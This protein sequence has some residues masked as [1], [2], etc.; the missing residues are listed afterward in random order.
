MASLHLSTVAA[1][2]SVL[3]MTGLAGKCGSNHWQC[4]DGAC[5]L[6]SWRC[7]GAGDCLDGSDE[8]DCSCPPEYFE[9][10]DGTLCVMESAVCDGQT[11]CPDGSDEL[12]CNLYEGCLT[13]D[14][15]C[16]NS[17]CISLSLRCNEFDDCGDGSDEEGCGYCGDLN[18]RCP[19]GTCLTLRERCDGVPHCSDGRDEPVTCG[20]MCRD[21]NGG[22]SH[23]CTDQLWGAMCSCPSG[24]KLSANGAKCEDVDECAQPYGPCM[25][26][27]I[28]TKGSFQCR[29]RPGFQLQGGNVCQTQ[30]N[31]TK[32]LTTK[33]GLLGLIAVNDRSFLPLTGI[34]SNPLALTFDFEQNLVFWADGNGNIYKTLD[35][36]SS[37]LYSGQTG[38]K[39]LAVD[40]LNGQLYWTNAELKG[41]YTGAYDGSSVGVVLSK[42]TDP[43]DLVLLPTE[44]TMFW[45]NKGPNILTIESAAMDGFL[46]TS[47]MV[48]TAQLPRG[49]A[50]DVAARRLYWI[51][52]FKKSVETVKVDGTG[53][54][55]FREFF[56]GRVG[57]NLAVFNG[58]FYWTEDRRLWQAPENQPS[59]KNFLLKGE[60]TTV[61]VYHELQQ[62]RGLSPC[63]KSGCQLC[64]PSLTSLSGYT[65]SCSEGKLSVQRGSCEWFK[66]AYATPTTIYTLEYTTNGPVKSI[67]FSSD[68]DIQAFDVDWKR[69]LVICANLTGHVK[70]HVLREGRSEYIPTLKP[71]C[72]VRVDQKTGNFYWVSC[73]E[74]SV[75]ATHISLPDQSVS[76]HLYQ[77]SGEINDLFVDWQRGQLYWLEDSQII[78]MKL[79]LLGGN[80]KAIYRSEDK[81]IGHVVF[82]RRAYSVVWHSQNELQVLSLLKRKKYTA[83]EGWTFPG[84]IAAAYEPYIVTVLNDVITLWKRQDGTRVKAVTVESA[85]VD[86]TVALNELQQ[87]APLSSPGTDCEKPSMLCKETSLCMQQAWLCDGTKDCPDGSDEMNCRELCSK[88]GDFQCK[89]GR[90]CVARYLLCN[91]RPDCTDGSDEMSCSPTTNT[92]NV[93]PLRCRLGSKLCRDGSD[94]VHHSHVC[95]GQF[96]CKDGS[97]EDGCERW[98]KADQFQCAHGRMCIDKKLVCDGTPQCQDRSDEM[99]CFTRTKSCSHRC[100]NKTRCIPDTFLCDGEKDCLD[101]TDE[102][103]C[104]ELSSVAATPKI[105][106]TPEPV[107]E[108]PSE[109]CPGTSLCISQ[110]QLCDGMLD[111]PDG[112][113]ELHCLHACSDPGHFLCKNKRKCV[114]RA[115]VCDGD[116]HCKDGSD[117]EDCGQ[118]PPGIKK[119]PEPVCESPSEMCPGTS[120]CISQSQLCDGMLDCPDGFDELHCLHTC[121]D[122]G[123]FLCKNKRKCVEQALLC[124]GRSDCSDGSDE[125]QCPTCPLH[126]DE[127]T[128]CLTSQQFCDGRMDCKDGL[129]ERNC[130]KPGK[131]P[132]KSSLKCP[133]GFKPCR[134]GSDCILYNHVCDG[135]KDCKDGSDERN[136][137]KQCNKDQFQCAHGRMCIDKKLVCDG[138]PQCQDR[139]DEMDCFTRTKS[140]S[141]RCD[142]KTRCISDTFLCDGEKDCLDGTDEA[143]CRELSSVAAT[144]KIEKTPE[145]VCENP[146]EMCPGT[147]LCISQSQLCDGMLDCPD[148]FDELHCLHACSDPGHFL[149]K[150]K[151][152]CVERALVCDGRSDCSDGSDE[153]QC[154]TCPLHCDEGTVCLT[155]QQFCDG[156][157]DC[158]D[159]LDERNCYKPGKK[160]TKSSLKCPLGFKPCRDGS[161]CILYN[162]VCD[163]EK[164]CKDGSDERN[165]EKQ[166][167]KDQFQCAH[168]RMCIDKKLVCD[169]TPQCQDRSDEMDCF[170]R[171]ESCSHRCDNKT[172]CIS[173]TFLCDG[174]KDCLDGTDEADCPGDSTDTKASS[175]VVPI[176]LSAN[177]DCRS[178]SMFCESTSL[179]MSPTQLCDGKLD[180]P[181]GSDELSCIDSCQ[182]KGD[183]LC[184]EQKKCI[185]VHLR[186]DGRS[187]CTDGSDEADCLAPGFKCRLGS[188]LC[189]DGSDCILNTHVCDGELDCKDGSDEDGCDLQCNQGQF[190]CRNSRMCISRKQV[191][192]GVPQ[193][194]DN[195][196]ESTC[197]KPSRSCALRCDQNSHC[198]PEIFICNGIR[199]CWDGSD[200]TDCGNPGPH[201]LCKSPFIPCLATSKCISQ[202]QLCDGKKDCTD[203]SDERPCLQSCPYDGDD[204]LCKDRRRCI[205]RNLVCDG[206]P[207]CTDA[208]DEVDCP[209]VAAYSTEDTPMKCRLG[210]TPCKD[211]SDCILHS[212]LCD[213]ENDCKDGSDEEGCDV[214]CKTGQFQCAHGRK[215]IDA[216]FVC[217]GKPQC[218]DR[219]DEMDCFQRTKSCSHR[220]DNKT[221]CIPK[222][223]LCDGERDCI[224]GTDESDCGYPTQ[225]QRCEAPSVLCRGGKLCI[226]NSKLCDGKRDCPDGF[227]EEAC[228]KKCPKSGD[229][230]CKDRRKCVENGLVCD[231]RPDCNDSSDEEGCPRVPVKPNKPG[232]LKCRLGWR[233]CKDGSKCV[234]YSHVCDGE[235]DCKDGSDEDDCQYQ[236]RPDQFQCAHGRLCIDKKLVC[237]GTPQC[238]DRSD[239]MDCFTRTKSCSHRCDNKTRCI[240]D[241]FLCDGEKDCLDGTD[242][243]DCTE[244]NTKKSGPP[245]LK[246][247]VGFRPC[248]DG[249]ECILSSHMCDGE[250]DCKDRS[251]EQ[252]CRRKVVPEA[253]PDK[254][255]PEPVCE[256]PSVMCP[257]TSLCISQSQLCDG[258]LDCPDGFDELHCLHACS[259]PGHFLCKNKRKCVE[260]ALVCDGRSDC[261]DGSDEAQCPTC[262]LHC[263]E[264]TVCLTS[265]QFCDGRMDCKD[266]FDEKKCHKGQKNTAGSSAL[267]CRL[268]FKPCRDGSECI[269]SS[270]VC[271]G[272][273]DCKD[274]SD[275]KDCER[276]CKKSQFQCAHGKMCIDQKQVC[277]GTPQCQDRSDEV[278]CFKPSESCS[279]HCDNRTRCI[280]ESFL[281]D[282]ERDCLDGTDETSCAKE[283]CL[284]GQFQ[285]VNGQCVPVSVR[286]DG[287]ADCYDQSD[288]KSC[289][290]PPH[291]PLEQRCPNSHVCL[292]K[293]WFCDGHKDCPDGSDEQNCKASPVQCGAFQ[294]SCASKDQ[295]IP[296]F[297]RCDGVN[298]CKDHS[299]E[300]GCG[301]TKCSTHM[302]KCGSEE[303]LDYRL[304]CDGTANCLDES[305]EGP[306]CRSNNCSGPNPPRCE[307]ICINTPHG[308]K[309][310]C[311]PGFRIQPDG[312]YCADV[313]ECMESRPPVCTHKC[314]N[315]HGS[316][317]CKCHP[318]FILE[319]D[320][321]SCKTQKE[322]S[323]L[324][325]VQYEVLFMGLRSSNMEMLLSPG[326]KPI[327]SLDYDWKEQRVFWVCLQEQSIKYAVHGEK[328]YIK[329]LVKGV[330]SDSIA[331]DWLARNL[332]WVD[333]VA[334]Q[335]LAVRIGDSVLKQQNVT[336]ILDEDLEQPRSLVLLPQKGIMLWSAIGK[337]PRIE[338]AGMDGSER[339]LLLGHGLNWPVALAVDIVTDRIYWADEKLQC[340]GSATMD[341]KDIRLLQL[342]ETS[343]LYSVAVFNDMVYWSDTRRQA[344]HGAHKL[345][346]KNRK[347]ILKRPGQPFGLK[348]V[349]PLIQYKVP[350]PCERLRCSH[351]C[352]LSPEGSASCRCPTGL[353]LAEDGFTCSP[354]VNSSSFLLLLSPTRLTKVFTR[355]L[356]GQVGLKQWPTHQAQSLPGINEALDMDLVLSD[357][358]L[359][360]A[361]VGQ[362][363]VAKI[364]LGD[365]MMPEL[366]MLQ[367]SGDIITALAVDWITHNLY[368][369][370]S[371]KPQIYATSAGGTFT[372][373]V[374]QAR[375]QDPTSIALHPPTG[376]MCFTAMETS[377]KDVLPQVDCAAMDGR[378]QMVLWRK[379]R[380]PNFLTFSS[381][382]TTVYW[383]DVATELICSVGI[384][385][386]NYREYKTG[387][388]SPLI[389][390]LTRSE[391][392]LFWITR[393]NGTTSVWFSDGI[394]PKKLWFEVE[395]NLIALK[396]FSTNSQKGTNLCAKN[397]GGCSHLCLAYPGG[398]TCRCTHDYIAVHENQCVSGD[399][400]PTGSKPCRDGYKCL[401]T[402]RFC[403]QIPDC[404]DG[405]DEEGCHMQE[406]EVLVH[407]MGGQSCNSDLCNGR[408]SCEMQKGKPVCNC[409][410]GYAGQFCQDEAS[411]SVPIILTVIFII[412]LVIL[413]AAVMRWRRWKSR[414]GLSLDKETLM[415]DMEEQEACS[416][417]FSNELYNPVEE[418][419][420][421]CVE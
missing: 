328:G 401:S 283:P 217:D 143:D 22:C 136:C 119:S 333:G 117:E 121:S 3:L 351:M 192:D 215:C 332:Y 11:Q 296:T 299:D 350:N 412:S 366:Q 191:C 103:D 320:G 277:D 41:I 176:T 341:G 38:I 324:A 407:A 194:P 297:W 45:I 246:C 259:D 371:K 91:G 174:E 392:I 25:H 303:C 368:W 361:D 152:K 184:K 212:H 377:G 418:E 172:R 13:G 70:V 222:N 235:V 17:I 68:E 20:K 267:K 57:Q 165:C 155:S 51:S 339:K 148:G 118:K 340:I 67:L 376:R 175:K 399:Q 140:C 311:Q 316:Y 334:G 98:C 47:L 403:D 396:A 273:K 53:R 287:H 262:P 276:Q 110:S 290:K 342:T 209:T 87:D 223:F 27:C 357:D 253:S 248:R 359:Y 237:D 420:S 249:S 314:M 266:G 383:A 100:D 293:E 134:D 9:C 15:K 220:C 421:T 168:G 352:V 234:L 239:E 105:E 289:R 337:K 292:L 345:T 365:S 308:A 398:R 409:A 135:E 221:R 327:F 93:A 394:Q 125:A 233:P 178:P 147:S 127:G 197:W 363:S 370:S 43:T 372:S 153:A 33:K 310:G 69:G 44:S 161:D 335:I 317:M 230:L 133:L 96:D 187:D 271:D 151:R 145:P 373:V 49:L 128:V 417:N 219:S 413:A 6:S 378:N 338:Q 144:P 63:R 302:F 329:T 300:A 90:N 400:C 390:S 112:F 29:C 251:D 10:F 169:G 179:C 315:T 362:A 282:G 257:G 71:V 166:C 114:E 55:T 306:G 12:N 395:T 281:C 374:L 107:C 95:D 405:S 244:S 156:R 321:S 123:H 73:D 157:M 232:P 242:E 231:G 225:L 8:M 14:W 124:D 154:P 196:D 284:R 213:G 48:V 275:E 238:Q 382:G 252:D 216:S 106:K 385:G 77:A 183:F 130:Y 150:N 260:R 240:P 115:L 109:M 50:L 265:Q 247:A 101:G 102:A 226:S 397:N 408:G 388:A 207:H 162:H 62:P 313:D 243:A 116:K 205:D 46:R 309:C 274:G 206:H 229:F 39:S 354:P 419:Q 80:A 74:L 298:D 142:N 173:D 177:Q 170:K 323:L 294:W 163:G 286:C 5:I 305:D 391:N 211:G 65:C 189:R 97:D 18:V 406:N 198:I 181:D 84:L 227:D 4:D 224:D 37:V 280:P 415:K 349:H 137:E 120:L 64:M 218:Q 228:F 195:S 56:K 199:D 245:S 364:K 347:V 126:C 146:S 7:D 369:S 331:V 132:T 32:L 99:D 384:D 85:I 188:K 54:H 360:V 261:S 402:T 34:S 301:Q 158:K 40:W 254:K 193:C 336:V 23:T 61:M 381:Q 66:L 411:S 164:D 94:C 21:K 325:S 204:F 270:H 367:L 358:T 258:M 1:V 241:T 210:L 35:Q 279:H 375:L 138:T 393:F 208:S 307:H 182:E 356:H 78:T 149:C 36:K 264:G 312:L 291:C 256:N 167:N 416:E 92:K 86:V 404:Q 111:C 59:K 202:S 250:K 344:I 272:E 88:R 82:D 278:N 122:P 76:S 343:S 89:D 79:G 319:P 72:V 75:G 31:D 42:D 353:L 19:N 326:L 180:C 28:N 255:T 160:P 269:L 380:L 108:N 386:S 200:E 16:K 318:E 30:G 201:S 288:E 171:T 81:S 285:C 346:G 83:G 24:M 387:T 139:S 322:P 52:E 190:Q 26:I 185:E 214:N 104:R 263:D 131:K 268:G 129:D 295:C 186:C 203:G 2:F 410:L 58:L 389:V 236:C 355:T 159:G 60:L 113:D 379:T 304:V 414:R 348:I 330:K 141:H